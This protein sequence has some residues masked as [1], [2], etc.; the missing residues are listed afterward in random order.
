[1]L[2]CDHGVIEEIQRDA[3]IRYAADEPELF[4]A[5]DSP[6]QK[7]TLLVDP[8]GAV[9]ATTGVLPTKAIRIP[10]DQYT[11]ALRALE[12]TFLS[13]PILTVQ[14]KINLPLPTEPGYAWKWLANSGDKWPSSDIAPVNSQA[15]WNGQQE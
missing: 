4:Q 13:T 2:L 14:G 6:P 8:R 1:Q 10:P 5:I 9:H 12:I 3:R 15:T 11:E 7:L